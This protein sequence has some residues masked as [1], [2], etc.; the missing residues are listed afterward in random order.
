MNE[1]FLLPSFA[2][3]NRF[4][5]SVKL[6]YYVETDSSCYQGAKIRQTREIGEGIFQQ[7]EI[8]IDR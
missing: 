4:S 5:S 1:V 6:L 2:V 3:L 7:P 8:Q